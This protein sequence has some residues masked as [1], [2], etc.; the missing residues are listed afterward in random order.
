MKKFVILI[1]LMNS[2][3]AKSQYQSIFGDST[4]SWSFVCPTVFMYNTF[5]TVSYEKDTVVN[6][7]ELKKLNTGVFILED[8]VQGKAW[9]YDVAN[10]TTSWLIQDFS[11][12]LEDSMYI[13]HSIFKAYVDSV[14]YQG[15]RKHIRFS[16]SHGALSPT[17]KILMIEGIGTTA[18]TFLHPDS[19]GFIDYMTCQHKDGQINF[20][21]NHPEWQ[22][23]CTPSVANLED[24][25]N[26]LF[27]LYPNPTSGDLNIETNGQLEHVTI[28]SVTG[29]VVLESTSSSI[30]ISNLQNG[31]YYVKVNSEGQI[32][33][34]K[35]IKN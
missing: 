35:V 2:L 19:P 33:S 4:T 9:E 17:E 27:E 25:E 13:P 10:A 15:G 32:L 21:N 26:E 12:E 34:K 20:A 29:A 30:N 3:S 28:Y 5:K 31:V 14:Y 1:I 22:G 7:L 23:D 11:L 6:S 8:T 16:R 18:N 24:I